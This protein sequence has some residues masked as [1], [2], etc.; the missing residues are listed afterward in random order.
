[1]PSP[2]LRFESLT[3]ASYARAANRANRAY[4][5]TFSGK[6]G[7]GGAG[8]IVAGTNG[9]GFVVAQTGPS[10]SMPL[11]TLT[12]VVG[13]KNQQRGLH[14]QGGS[15]A[16]V[17]KS[18]FGGNVAGVEIGHNAG[19]VVDTSRLDLGASVASDGGAGD[20]GLNVLQSTAASG[21]QNT[22]AGVCVS[23][24]AAD[25]N[26]PL[27]LYGNVWVTAAGGAALDCSTS[28]GALSTL[29]SG[30]TGAVDL[31]GAVVSPTNANIHT[32]SCTH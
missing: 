26:Q 24:S 6:A 1:M 12:G 14:L 17:R 20:P 28:T 18:Y 19:N 10:G 2:R 7:V 30:C 16:K 11:V 21:A 31:A 3:I 22:G 23:L 13:W 32:D 25:T 27:Y 5:I 4:A 15:N 8:S 29:G 9:N